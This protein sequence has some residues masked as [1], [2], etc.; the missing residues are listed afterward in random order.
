[1][2]LQ[3]LGY[4][5]HLIFTAFDGKAQD[6]GDHWEIHT[7]SNPNFF[8]GNLLIFARPPKKGDFSTWT[9]QFKKAFANRDVHHITLA[10]QSCS[11]EIGDISEFLANDFLLEST[12]VLSA[13][14]VIRPREFREDLEVRPLRTP[15]EWEKMV[16]IQTSSA[17]GHLTRPIWEAFYQSQAKRFQKMQ[18]AGFG[19]W[20]G[21]FLKGN[22][23]AGLGIFHRN[24]LG[25]FQIVCTDPQ[26]QRQGI[27]RTLV[28]QSS[29]L[30]LASGHL[31]TL[32][33]CADPDYHAIK[34]YEMVG[35]QR[36]ITEHG[37]YWWDK[38]RQH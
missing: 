3:S 37:V 31:D 2:Q 20:Y 1:M 13:S 38:N 10:W 29:Q 33:M 11:S 34:I 8:W 22:L 23:V 32:V 14:V 30:A 17:H 7:L 25:R 6:C 21:G 26:F 9:S 4:Q 12:I 36:Q 24:R 35:F 27:C 28:Y 16:E 15:A 5:S 19:Q 18:S